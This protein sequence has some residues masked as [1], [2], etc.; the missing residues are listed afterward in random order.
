M[1]VCVLS[2]C[3]LL[4]LYFAQNCIFNIALQNEKSGRTFLLLLHG[5]YEAN[6]FLEEGFEYLFL[7]G[8]L[9]VAVDVRPCLQKLIS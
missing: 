9:F 1:C 3:L 8:C 6:T 5:S 4:L 2:S 7:D